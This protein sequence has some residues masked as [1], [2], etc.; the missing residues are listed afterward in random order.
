MHGSKGRRVVHGMK[1]REGVNGR[2]EGV[3]RK[4]H[5]GGGGAVNSQC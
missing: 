3:G 1:G 5:G 2:L 4:M